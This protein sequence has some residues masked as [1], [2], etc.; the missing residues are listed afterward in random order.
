MKQTT[1][2][3]PLG[4][5]AAVLFLVTP[6]MTQQLPAPEKII[7]D[8][9]LANQYLMN[10]WPDPTVP[11]VKDR[12]RPSNI[13]TRAAYYEGLM[14]LYRVDPQATYYDYAVQWGAGHNWEPAYGGTRTENA[15]NQCCGQTY[16]ELY[17]V[18]PKPERIEKIKETIDRM[19]NSDNNDAW[20][21]IDA[22]QMA[23]PVFAK[24]GAIYEDDRYFEKMYSLYNFSKTQQG[25]NGLYNPEDHLWWRDAD[26]EPPTTSPN[27]EDTYW[28]RGNGWVLT[29]LARVLDVMPENAPHREEY[30]TTFKEM[31]EALVPIQR[32]DGFWNVSLHDPEEFGGKE[33]SGT[34][35][36]V[37]GLAWGVNQGLLTDEKY[38]TAAV[39]GWN[40]L[41][42]DALHE[43]GFLGY[44]QGTGKQPSD[45]QPLS[46][47]K[48]ANFED[49]GLGAFL[50]AGS[51]MF[52]MAGGSV[53]SSVEKQ[54]N[55]HSQPERVK[56]CLA[57]P[58]PLNPD[59][60][61]S[62]SLSEENQVDLMVFDTLGKR[63]FTFCESENQDA[64]EYQVGWN[65]MDDQGNSAP[66]GTYIIQIKAGD[67]VRSQKVTVIR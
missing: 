65:G 8:M 36:F 38:K 67:T 14:M 5:L 4:L 21:W 28:S 39:R 20:W 37:F 55:H 60:R 1:G 26:F 7:E 48:P 25:E 10:K 64:G 41:V 19:L 35:F 54:F 47:D 31:A 24:L 56:L 51:E 58:N 16:I 34:G 46:Y 27:G 59:T 9:R 12:V 15:D 32:E 62:Y 63:I 17:Q 57:Y 53:Q 13:W 18:D 6:L 23:M 45:G 2:Y 61:I 50:L 30:L 40:G 42:N 11:T 52:L 33:T 43:N 3:S 49:Y 66:S 44:V 29:A 22:L